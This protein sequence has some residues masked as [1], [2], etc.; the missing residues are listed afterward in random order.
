M[1]ARRSAPSVSL[2]RS[3]AVRAH[4]VCMLLAVATSAI[5]L[6]CYLVYHYQAGSMPFR[7]GGPIA[8]GLLHDLAFPHRSGDV[9]RRSAGDSD[10]SSGRPA[11]L[12]ETRPN[13]PSHF[14]HLAL[15][16]GH[17]RRDLPAALPPPVTASS[18]SRRPTQLDRPAC[19]HYHHAFTQSPKHF[20][21]DGRA[22]VCENVT[23]AVRNLRAITP[24]TL[25]GF[26]GVK[27]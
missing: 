26:D 12:R 25:L 2:A 23:Y 17:R 10:A 20:L 14:S 3:P 16:L 24:L 22:A 13:R 21:L 1:S 6:A 27:H 18:A 9:R 4:V 15:C 11:R 5:F 8:L 19:V 7:H